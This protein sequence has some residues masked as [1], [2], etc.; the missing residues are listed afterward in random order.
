MLQKQAEIIKLSPLTQQV[1]KSRN[2]Q[3]HYW[4][5]INYDINYVVTLRHQLAV[6]FNQLFVN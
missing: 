2:F 1:V 5:G 4:C 6:E 3:F